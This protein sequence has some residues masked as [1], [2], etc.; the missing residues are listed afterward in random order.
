MSHWTEECKISLL[1]VG[2]AGKLEP[3]N[4][5]KVKNQN[6]GKLQNTPLKFR[7]SGILYPK[8]YFHYQKQPLYYWTRWRGKKITCQ[9]P[10]CHMTAT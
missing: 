7:V 1:H 6:K 4:R 8:V 9:M 10:T 3:T 2:L 5:S